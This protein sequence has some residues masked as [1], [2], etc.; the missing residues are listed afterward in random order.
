MGVTCQFLTMSTLRHLGVVPSF[1]P[2]Q[3]IENDSR[4]LPK[5]FCSPNEWPLNENYGYGEEKMLTGMCERAWA[6]E[7]IG[8]PH[9]A[10]VVI[11]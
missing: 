4:I 3:D 11:S 5:D 8:S 1:G 10:V 9:S 6:T 2:D 7:E